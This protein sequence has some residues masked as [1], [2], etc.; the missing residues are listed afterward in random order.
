MSKIKSWGRKAV[1]L[2]SVGMM[3]CLATVAAFASDVS[4]NPYDDVATQVTGEATKMFSS[5][6]TVVVA[7]ISGGLVIFGIILLVKLVKRGIGAAVGR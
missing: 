6:Q 3:G 1:A 2:L 7:T 5:A 4:A